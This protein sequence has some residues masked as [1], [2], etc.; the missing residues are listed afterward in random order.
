MKTCN[1]PADFN[2]DLGYRKIPIKA[3]LRAYPDE[4][5]NAYPMSLM[6]VPDDPEPGPSE[7]P[8]T[9]SHAKKES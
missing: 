6:W 5:A 8:H 9:R 1:V 4:V 3:G 7:Q 2:L